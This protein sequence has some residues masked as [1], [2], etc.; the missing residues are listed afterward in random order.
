MAKRRK[1]ARILLT[2]EELART[3]EAASNDGLPLATWFRMV[4]LEAAKKG[5]E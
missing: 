4:A 1:I 3:K 2:E 5:G